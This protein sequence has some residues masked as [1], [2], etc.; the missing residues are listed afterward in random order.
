MMKCGEPR[1]NFRARVWF[2]HWHLELESECNDR[3]RQHRTSCSQRSD[4]NIAEL[5]NNRSVLSKKVH[6]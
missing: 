6:Q 2:Q 5:C 4:L 3:S 1:E